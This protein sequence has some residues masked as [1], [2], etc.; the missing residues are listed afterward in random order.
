M[1]GS[2]ATRLAGLNLVTCILRMQKNLKHFSLKGSK[3]KAVI[4]INELKQIK[5][6]ESEI[7]RGEKCYKNLTISPTCLFLSLFRR[8][9]SFILLFVHQLFSRTLA[10]RRRV[11]ECEE[12]YN[13]LPPISA[14]QHTAPPPPGDSLFPWVIPLKICQGFSKSW[15]RIKEVE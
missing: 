15:V 6:M 5:P 14:L 3:L 4:L 9:I 2:F 13:R 10:K 11:E 7:E 12:C 1:C 8:K